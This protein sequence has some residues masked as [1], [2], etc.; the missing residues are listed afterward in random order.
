MKKQTFLHNQ[1][2]RMLREKTEIS[3]IAP[4]RIRCINPYNELGF[5]YKKTAAKSQIKLHLTTA[6]L[7]ITY[8]MTQ[9]NVKIQKG[10]YAVHNI[11]PNV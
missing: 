3:S 4:P 7:K 6:F 5:S 10:A 9:I 11:F 1:I 2:T 8:N